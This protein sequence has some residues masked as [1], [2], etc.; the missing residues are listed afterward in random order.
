VNLVAYFDEVFDGYEGPQCALMRGYFDESGTHDPSRVT[1]IAGFLASKEQWRALLPVW[2]KAL[3]IDG[4]EMGVFH[5]ADFDHYAKHHG[6]SETKRDKFIAKLASIA[7]KYTWCGVSGSII[8]SDYD[9]LPDWV[10]RKIGGRYHFAFAV[11]MHLLQL[12]MSNVIS[13]EPTVLTFDRKDG[14]VGRVV[15]DFNDILADGSRLGPLFFDSKDRCPQLQVADLLVYEMN[16]YIDEALLA[17]RN[18]RPALK[19]F[20]KRPKI[21]FRYHDAETL[22]G[23]PNLLEMDRAKIGAGKRSLD[24]WWPHSWHRNYRRPKKK[25]IDYMGR[26]P[27]RSKRK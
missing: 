18:V 1:T 20:A 17:R 24:L 10:R 5:S 9:S 26:S 16:H 11:I 14:V 6:W 22:V 3:T 19:E 23:L 13:S 7:N 15:E 2:E 25:Y 21:H 12:R 4:E 27:D 8:V